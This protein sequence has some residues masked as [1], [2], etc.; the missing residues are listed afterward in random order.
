MA[1]YSGTPLAKKLGIT[2]GF[3]VLAISGP[4]DLDEWLEP[5]PEGVRIGSRFR[6]ADIVLVFATTAAQMQSGVER[7]LSA[8]PKE[9]AM[10]LCWP[11]KASG[12]ESELQSRDIV[13]DHM[14]PLGLVDV[15]VAA[16]SDVWSG[17]RFVIRKELR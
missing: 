17:L 13:M 16:I 3:K 14:L 12:I 8:L 10:W 4:A 9:G 2:D 1:G 5:L 11:K 15:K 7:A 6:T